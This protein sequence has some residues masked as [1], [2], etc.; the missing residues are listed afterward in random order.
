MLLYTVLEV[1]ISSDSETG[2]FR[3]IKIFWVSSLSAA[4]L[5]IMQDESVFIFH[6]G[7]FPLISVIRYNDRKC[8]H[9]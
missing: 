5:F 7:F 1:I 9:I 2:I 8:K 4:M 6:E 3:E